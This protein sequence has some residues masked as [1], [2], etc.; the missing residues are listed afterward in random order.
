MAGLRRRQGAERFSE[1]R[2]SLLILQNPLAQQLFRSRLAGGKA[3]QI[4]CRSSVL[5]EPRR[6]GPLFWRR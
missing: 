5:D 3:E 2:G 4:R 1:E 6:F